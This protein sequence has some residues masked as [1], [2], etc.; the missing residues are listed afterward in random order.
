MLPEHPWSTTTQ[1]QSPA[2]SDASIA[3]E[4]GSAARIQANSESTSAPVKR[5]TSPPAESCTTTRARSPLAGSVPDP[6]TGSRASPTEAPTKV[7]YDEVKDQ[8]PSGQ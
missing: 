5:S 6:P 2:H 1:Y 7:G 4:S 8:V 3:R